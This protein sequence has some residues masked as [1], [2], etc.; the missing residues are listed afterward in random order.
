MLKLFTASQTAPAINLYAV[1]EDWSVNTLDYDDLPGDILIKESI[2]VQAMGARGYYSCDITN[3]DD[4]DGGSVFDEYI[5]YGFMIS[6]AESDEYTQIY[7][8]EFTSF[9]CRPTLVIEYSYD[10]A[11]GLEDGGVY[12]FKNKASNQYLSVQGGANSNGT[13][14]C[15]SSDDSL[16]RAQAFRLAYE[17]DYECFRIGAICSSDGYGKVLDFSYS[18]TATSP[19]FANLRIYDYDEEDSAWEED[20]VWLIVPDVTRKYF[21]ILSKADPNL[22][23]TAYGSAGEDTPGTTATSQGNVFV[24]EFTGA[25][26]QLWKIESGDRQIGVG[27]SIKS[28]GTYDRPEGST[29]FSFVCPVTAYGETVTWSSNNTNTATV[30]QNG[31]VTCLKAGKSIITAT[32]M[33]TDGTT[34]KYTA[35]VYVK[36]KDGVYYMVNEETGYRLEYEDTTDYSE[37][38]VMEVYEYYEEDEEEPPRYALFKIK[39]LGT[40]QYSIRSMLRNDM[41]WT[42][43]SDS[44]L[45]MTNVGTSDSDI[46]DTEKWHIVWDSNGYYIYYHSALNTVTAT[47]DSGDNVYSYRY[48]VSD[49]LQHWELTKVTTTMNGVVIYDKV[50][51]LVVDESASF[52]AAIY[53]SD[54]NQNG[55]NGFT[56]S[57]TS[58]SEFASIDSS[59]GVL[60]A[61]APGSVTIKAT[62]K[63]YTWNAVWSVVIVPIHDGTYFFRNVEFDDKYI[64][65]NQNVSPNTDGAHMEIFAFDSGEDQR[66]NVTHV[67]SGYYKIVSEA[68][69]YALTAPTDNNQSITQ[70]SYSS[71]NSAQKWIFAKLEDG[72]YKIS[73]LSDTSSYMAASDSILGSSGRNVQKRVAQS[74]G[75]DEWALLLIGAIQDIEL[76]PQQKFNWCWA[77]SARMFASNYSTNSITRTQTQAVTEVL[78]SSADE[79]GSSEEAIEA[80]NYYISGSTINTVNAISVNW[81]IYT[82]AIM[83]QFLDDGHV[84]YIN[85]TKYTD[86]NDSNSTTWAHATIISGY[87]YIKDKCW[88]LMLDPWLPNIGKYKI[89]SYENL[90]NGRNTEFGEESEIYVWTNSIVVETEYSDMT[91]DYYF[92]NP[93]LQ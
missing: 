72:T 6:C 46:D 43:S 65:I 27:Y 69:G 41:G 83:K 22:A 86:I 15:L 8:S 91:I 17:S 13:N 25:N 92:T 28:G 38:A 11:P 33:H 47:E 81:K 18:S 49:L 34:T 20:Q 75:K 39:Y 54:I 55:Q 24:S 64:Q 29:N 59:T 19:Q 76:E 62:Y 23:I 21:S 45:V 85:R 73:P 93:D 70:T 52:S 48:L 88:L 35:T 37:G 40:G 58:G 16:G 4:L 42:F 50:N 51:K 80:I 77:A 87:M 89:I 57:I 2:D 32:V 67:G 84:L 53:S 78:G 90:V 9:G 30:N 68:S 1:T 56:W 61:I 7:S 63:R 26:N 12:S 3:V 14:V 44:E 74:D 71:N 31:E 79:P 36:I 60:T 66:W 10:P 5:N 82:E